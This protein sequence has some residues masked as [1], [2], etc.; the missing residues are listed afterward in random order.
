VGGAPTGTG[1]AA[2]ARAQ[3]RAR[4]AEAVTFGVASRLPPGWRAEDWLARRLHDDGGYVSVPEAAEAMGVTTEEVVRLADEGGARRALRGRRTPLEA[5]ERDRGSGALDY[6][7]SILAYWS[8]I[9]IIEGRIILKALMALGPLF[10][11]LVEPT[12]AGIDRA[13]AELQALRTK[14]LGTA[15]VEQDTGH[16]SALV[17]LDDEITARPHVHDVVK[18]YRHFDTTSRSREMLK[19]LPGGSDNGLTPAEVGEQMAPHDRTGKPLTPGSV[20]A[21]YR[22]IRRAEAHLRSFGVIKG[23]IVRVSFDAYHLEG[24]GRYYIEQDARAALDA[25]LNRQKS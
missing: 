19:E 17:E 10:L 25:Y 8:P 14:L 3:A 22:N 2:R 20:R 18:L 16:G 12:V 9:A 4:E 23:P 13:I 1:R 11:L 21:V 5:R 15:D 7:G 6:V 24:S